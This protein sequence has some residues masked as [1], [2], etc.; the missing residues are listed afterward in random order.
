MPST[1][2]RLVTPAEAAAYYQVDARTVRRW[3]RH[4]LIP[5]QK[6]P[7]GQWRI[8]FPISPSPPPQETP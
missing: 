4:G 8:G 5:A 2:D 1:E 7:G 6:T 3:A